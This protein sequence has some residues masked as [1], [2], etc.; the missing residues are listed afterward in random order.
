M[1]LE[2]WRS[3]ERCDTGPNVTLPKS[4]P[5]ID[6]RWGLDQLLEEEEGDPGARKL[7]RQV[8]TTLPDPDLRNTLQLLAEQI[9]RYDFDQARETLVALSE[10]LMDDRDA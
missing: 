7:L 1:E 2:F 5:G 4:L 3:T 9:E 10:N 6:L 8:E